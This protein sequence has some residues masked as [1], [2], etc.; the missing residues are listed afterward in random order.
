MILDATD[1]FETR[2]LLN[3]FCVETGVPWIYGAAVGSYGLTMPILPGDTACL[4][5]IYPNPPTGAQPT[6]ET[7]GVLGFITMFIAT[8]Q[9]AEALKLL[10]GNAAMVRRTILTADL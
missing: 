10:S 1:N 9:A 4:R 2:Y 8:I 5:C 6:C 3:D 7:A